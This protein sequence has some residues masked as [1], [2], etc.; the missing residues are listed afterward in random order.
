MTFDLRRSRPAVNFMAWIS[1]RDAMHMRGLA[2]VRCPS[3][4]F[5]YCVETAK[6]V[7]KQCVYPLMFDNNFGRCGPIFK[8]LSPTDVQENSLCTHTHTK[9]STSTCFS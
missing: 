5:V 3:M 9:I 6:D 4:T 2:V 8:I 1:P 7:A